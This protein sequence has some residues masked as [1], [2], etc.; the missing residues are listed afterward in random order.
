VRVVC[1]F[2]ILLLAGVKK[3]TKNNE[4]LRESSGGILA[5]AMVREYPPGA[6]WRIWGLS[7]CPIVI[8]KIISLT[9]RDIKTVLLFSTLM[10][11]KISDIQKNSRKSRVFFTKQE[12]KTIFNFVE[13]NG[14]KNF[15]GIESKIKKRTQKKYKERWENVSHLLLFRN[16]RLLKKKMISLIW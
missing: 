10:K 1:S 14:F 13:D 2:V 8:S 7:E 6:A 4:L 16:K 12:H 9:L 11:E 5:T 3:L 15:E